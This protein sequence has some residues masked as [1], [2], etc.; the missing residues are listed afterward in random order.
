MGGLVLQRPGNEVNV[1][2]DSLVGFHGEGH[3]ATA[4]N[5]I[6][7]DLDPDA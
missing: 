4:V 1:M 3:N 5:T 6:L 7:A 2:S